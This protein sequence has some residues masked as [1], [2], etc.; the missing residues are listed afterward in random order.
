MTPSG[1]AD[2]LLVAGRVDRA[3]SIA[4][5]SRRDAESAAEETW[6]DALEFA[7]NGIVSRLAADTTNP[8]G[9]LGLLQQAELRSRRAI[10]KPGL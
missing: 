6:C 10:S 3:H 5:R 7:A 9:A 8:D 2:W 4:G 1:W